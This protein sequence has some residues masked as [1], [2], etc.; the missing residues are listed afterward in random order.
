MNREFYSAKQSTQCATNT[1]YHP[2][3]VIYVL[4]IGSLG[5]NFSFLLIAPYLLLCHNVD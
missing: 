4:V 2:K 3:G 5:F 1:A